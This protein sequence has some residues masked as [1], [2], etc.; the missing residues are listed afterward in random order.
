[1]DF[2]VGSIGRV[3]GLR[4][5]EGEHIYDEIISLADKQGVKS[6]IVMLLG[7]MRSGKVVVGPKSPTGRPEPMFREF[8]DAREIVG[9]GTIFPDED[10]PKLHFHASIGRGDEVITGCPRLAAT[11]FCVLEGVMIELE[12]IEGIRELDPET[13]FKLLKFLGT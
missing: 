5:Y 9:F 12:G 3:F 8:N 10:G 4:F 13:G 7:G 6:G 2:Q 1:M 11:V